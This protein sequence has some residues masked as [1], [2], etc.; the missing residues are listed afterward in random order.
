MAFSWIFMA[1]L[2]GALHVEVIE[3]D[4]QEPEQE[5]TPLEADAEA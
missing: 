1:F 5:V 4:C 3:V 2:I